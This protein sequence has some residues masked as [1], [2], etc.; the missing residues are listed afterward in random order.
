MQKPSPT[1]LPFVKRAIKPA[2]LLKS[3]SSKS[4][5]QLVSFSE[6]SS[7]SIT[8]SVIPTIVDITLRDAAP[9]RLHSRSFH[10][11][12]DSS[13]FQLSQELAR[14]VLLDA[15]FITRSVMSTIDDT[16]QVV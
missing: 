10:P 14:P 13:C 15:L 1:E 8:R 7:L 6:A 3:Q 11:A 9:S 16:A 5:L 12:T 4:D 2:E